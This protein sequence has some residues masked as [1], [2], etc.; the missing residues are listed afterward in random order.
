MHLGRDQEGTTENRLPQ[1]PPLVSSI[2][3]MDTRLLDIDKL[4]DWT[5]NAVKRNPKQPVH[6]SGITIAGGLP[7]QQIG[8][9]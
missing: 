7:C 6:M 2:H 5:L 9:L 1:S 4:P 8:G 3:T